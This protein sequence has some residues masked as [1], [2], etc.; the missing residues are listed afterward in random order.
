MIAPGG[1]QHDL[2]V[3]WRKKLFVLLVLLVL[4]L[5]RDHAAAGRPAPYLE[6]YIKITLLFQTPSAIMSLMT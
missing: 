5:A 2:T 4:V 3:G 6:K 1:H